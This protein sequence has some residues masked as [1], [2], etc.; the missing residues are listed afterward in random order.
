MRVLYC[1][2]TYPPQV[3]GVSIV[4][5]VSVAG[6]SRAGWECAVAAPRYPAAAHAAW[7]REAAV[8]RATAEV[9][10]FASVA[11]P[12]YPDYASAGPPI[13]VSGRS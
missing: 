3:N 9:H 2:D 6:L 11:I 8:E 4:T 7:S 13:A 12:G 5:A 1:T 10:S